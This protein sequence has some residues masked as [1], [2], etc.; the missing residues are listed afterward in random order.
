M[1]GCGRDI[2]LIS[3]ATP[4]RPALLDLT[5]IPGALA[6]HLTSTSTSTSTSSASRATAAA[7]A[8]S[9]A[10]TSRS[11]PVMPSTVQVGSELPL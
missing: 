7:A 4:C 1:G 5:E 9:A 8:A 2:R 6:P 11:G 10:G 3:V